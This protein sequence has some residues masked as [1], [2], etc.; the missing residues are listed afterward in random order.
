[1]VIRRLPPDFTE[2]KFKSLYEPF[3]KNVTWSYFH[4]GRFRDTDDATRPSVGYLNFKSHADIQGFVQYA[5]NMVFE[6][7]KGGKHQVNTEY[8]PFQRVPKVTRNRD[9][10]QGKI[11]KGKF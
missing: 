10:R 3:A 5:M 2:E 8:A 11:F 6:D 9:P 4:Q 7:A 1:M